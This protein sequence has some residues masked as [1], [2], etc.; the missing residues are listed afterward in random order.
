M[1]EAR[2][3]AA[4]R[5]QGVGTGVVLFF[6]LASVG[7]LLVVD[8]VLP[9]AYAATGLSN[10][11]DSFLFVA[12]VLALFVPGYVRMTRYT[13]NGGAMYA[14]VT[15]GLGRVAG[16]SV[17]GVATIAY[18]ILDVALYG[19]FG[20]QMVAFAAA[21]WGMSPN[22]PWW[23]WALAVWALVSIAGQFKIR[24]VGMVLALL[25]CCEIVITLV[26]S[27]LGLAHAPSAGLW[28]PLSLKGVSWSSLGPGLAIASLGFIGFET[29]AVYR[30]E[31][32]SPRRTVARATF[33]CLLGST[34]IYTLASW[35]MSAYYGAHTVQVAQ[36]QGPAMFFALG[37]PTEGTIASV[38]MLTS[39]LAARIGY[40]QT[41]IRLAYVG[42]VA[43]MTPSPL[44]RTGSRGVPRVSAVVE[45]VAGLGTIGLTQLLHWNP[46][47]QLF[48]IGGTAGGW[49]IT[50]V[51]AVT[52]AAIAA[53]FR[54]E[55]RG[56]PLWASIIL[57]TLAAVALAVAAVLATWHFGI[58]IGVTPG[59]NAT[60]ALPA[61][62]ALIAV[63]GVARALYLKYLKP[64]RYVG[65]SVAVSEPIRP[66]VEPE[67]QPEAAR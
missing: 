27:G 12:V 34:L 44:A 31:A 28:H 17:Y 59:D 32:R 40:S 41:W 9:S 50:C 26:I 24:E 58:L 65:L 19:I 5:S 23:P 10:I 14:I 36:A 47:G 63:A 37:T 3:R 8:G 15:L 30:R 16:V 52:S 64:D 49:A 45:S 21:H 48:Y 38:L 61:L 18:L 4:D 33:L 35:S 2:T 13:P 56:E 60:Y 11:T 57:P 20:V 1:M 42:A 25:T 66:S 7:V 39:L 43:G 54:R 46:L 53:F 55:R 51:L 67:L 62:F 6:A 29:T 22:D